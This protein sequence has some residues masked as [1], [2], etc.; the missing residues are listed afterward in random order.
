VDVRGGRLTA[1]LVSAT[2]ATSV[3]ARASSAGCQ[4]TYNVR[5]Q[6]AGGFSADVAIKNLG[7]T[8]IPC[9]GRQTAGRPILRIR[10]VD[11]SFDRV[12]HNPWRRLDTP[13][14]RTR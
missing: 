7:V 3:M 4:V 8:P 13:I 12:I 2:A 14:Q 5:S 10:R 6:W 9:R 1:C 11:A